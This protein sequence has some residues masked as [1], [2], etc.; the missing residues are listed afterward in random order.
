M[1]THTVN[2]KLCLIA[3]FYFCLAAFCLVAVIPAA[4]AT[5]FLSDADAPLTLGFHLEYLGNPD[6]ELNIKKLLEVQ[7]R[8]QWQKSA[9][10]NLNL[11]FTSIPYWFRVTVNNPFNEAKTR[12]LELAYPLHNYLEFYQVGEGGVLAEVKVSDVRTTK[13]GLIEHRNIVFPLT[14]APHSQNTIYIHIMTTGSLQVPLRLW[15]PAAFYRHDQQVNIF[16]GMFY[17]IM[18][19][20]VFYNLFLF[21]SIKERVYLY[22]VVYVSGWGCFQACLQGILHYLWPEM[23]IFAMKTW[24]LFFMG[25]GLLGAS[26]FSHSFLQLA[27]YPRLHL[28]YKIYLSLL[29]ILWVSSLFLPY[30]IMARVM[31][32]YSAIFALYLFVIGYWSFFQGNSTARL[33]ATAWTV[34]LMG[35]LCLALDHF[36]VIPSNV[37]TQN[38]ASLGAVI[39]VTLLSFA[40]A[41]RY[42]VIRHEKYA[43]QELALQ[44]ELLI[45]EEQERATRMRAES[46]ERELSAKR[47][48]LEAQAE[49]KAKSQFLAAMSHEIRTPMN[50]VIGMTE[51]LKDSRLDDTQRHYVRVIHNSGKA[52]L[53]IIN[54]ILDYSKLNA[55]EMTFENVE[56]DIHELC[57]ECIAIFS[58]AAE[59]KRL[60]IYCKVAPQVPNILLGD[61]T[62]L[63]QILLNLLGNSLKF[64]HAGSITLSLRAEHSV[65]QENGHAQFYFSVTDTGIGISVENQ[66]KL[67]TAFKQADNSTV[68]KYGGT[69]LG[70]SISKQLVELMAGEIGVDSQEGTGSTFWFRLPLGI[71]NL[72]SSADHKFHSGGLSGTDPLLTSA[73]TLNHL[74]VLVAEDNAVSQMVIKGMLNKFGCRMEI[75]SNGIDVIKAYREDSSRYDVILMDCEMPEKDGFSASEEI[76]QFEQE[77]QIERIHIIALTAHAMSEYQQRCIEAGMD[78]HIAKPVELATLRRALEPL[79]KKA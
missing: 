73:Q 41:D 77:Q 78:D 48:A 19:V 24:L 53:Q 75:V 64:T 4:H 68:R 61:P 62:R 57:D 72:A 59:K 39:E 10:E 40:L 31:T 16:L 63:R 70:L 52:L 71:A 25:Y 42:N 6:N 5:V 26:L 18:L 65:T 17:G 55:G 32:G 74:N 23:S 50:G 60:L 36:S 56:F 3:S 44:K 1:R 12:L 49:N 8:L 38:A 20:M 11:G 67:F 34:L 7:H 27:T 13:D 21:L 29:F 69:G 15:E 43:A 2:Q 66:Q 45:F 76:R 33:F 54:D 14:F 46:A 37:I 28:T 35:V 9:R 79:A 51:L 47:S 58:L 22:Y 30:G